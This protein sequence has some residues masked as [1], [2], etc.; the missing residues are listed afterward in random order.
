MPMPFKAGNTA[1]RLG[2]GKALVPFVFVF[3][4]SLL[5]VTDGFTWR[6]SSWPRAGRCWASIRSRRRSRAGSSPRSMRWER[7]LLIVAAILLVAPALIPTLI[8]LALIAPVVVRQ[9]LYH[10]GAAAEV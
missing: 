4:P 1:F 9:L 2:M 7:P 3:S 10:R 8:G 6:T 5:L